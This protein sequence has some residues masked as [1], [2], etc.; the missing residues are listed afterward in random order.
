LFG[1]VAVDAG[2]DG[3]DF[4]LELL[5]VDFGGGAAW[6]EDYIYRHCE[7][8]NV[9]AD[10][11]PHA[12]LDSVAD[13]CV[14]E[15]FWNCEADAGLW[16]WTRS[17]E[18]GHLAA[19]LAAAFFVDALEVGVFAEAVVG[20]RFCSRDRGGM[21]RCGHYEGGICTRAAHCAGGRAVRGTRERFNL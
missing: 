5:D 19:V 12:A 6:V 15:G 1:E 7:G 10:G 21:E 4:L 3:G 8:G 18:P 16:F 14:A 9:F 13:D 11:G 20:S 2:E 17:A